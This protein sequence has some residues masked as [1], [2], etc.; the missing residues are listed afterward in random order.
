MSIRVLIAGGL[1]LPSLGGFG[2]AS[3]AFGQHTMVVQVQMQARPLGPSWLHPM[4]FP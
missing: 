1:L 2:L 3:P 4:D